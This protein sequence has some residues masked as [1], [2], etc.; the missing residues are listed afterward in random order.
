MAAAASTFGN[1][2]GCS[3]EPERPA[4][5]SLEDGSSRGRTRREA[6][7]AVSEI[8]LEQLRK[9]RCSGKMLF[10]KQFHGTGKKDGGKERRAWKKEVELESQRQ[11]R[12]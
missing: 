9:G 2:R 4:K 5:A 11:Q 8:A 12:V 3:E 7:P 1:V 6:E 10:K